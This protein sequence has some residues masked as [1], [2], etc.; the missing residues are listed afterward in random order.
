MVR[1]MM[2]ITI[3]IM[4]IHLN[5]MKTFNLYPPTFFLNTSML[6]YLHNAVSLATLR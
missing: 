3:I 1:M 2:M 5:Y 6:K 4:I